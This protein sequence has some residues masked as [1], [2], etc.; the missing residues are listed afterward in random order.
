MS[1]VL[2]IRKH[3]DQVE[4]KLRL[5]QM[6]T[7]FE[8]RV[9]LLIIDLNNPK[10]DDL[11]TMMMS[12]I[13]MWNKKVSIPLYVAADYFSLLLATFMSDPTGATTLSKEPTLSDLGDIDFLNA[14]VLSSFETYNYLDKSQEFYAFA[15]DNSSNEE[16]SVFYDSLIFHIHDCYAILR[17][18]YYDESHRWR[19]K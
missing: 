2:S 11:Q 18:I 10:I 1:E 5:R 3:P 4:E 19:N 15:K 9:N 16:E 17:K 6:M 14:I 7:E 13:F 8:D 12:A